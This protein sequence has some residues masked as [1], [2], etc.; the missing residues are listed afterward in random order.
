MTDHHQTPDLGADGRLLLEAVTAISSDLDLASVLT[1]I[2][3]AA[4]AL[5]GARYGA[6][7]VLGSTGDLVEFVTTGLDERTR[8]LIGDLPRGR[9]ILGVIIDDPSG[10]RLA[11]LSAHPSSVGFPPNHPPMTSFLGMPVRIRGTVFGNLYL[12]EKTGDGPFTEAD[13]QL[14]EELA[15]TAGYV[16]SNARSFALSERRRQWLEASAELSELLQPPVDLPSALDQIVST[17]RQ[18]SHARAVALWSSRGPEH[19]TVSVAPDAD[20]DRV[21][22]L[23]ARARVVAAPDAGGPVHT[24]TVDGVPVVVVPLRSHL[25]PVTALVAVAQPGAGLLDVQDRD[26]FAGFADQVALSLDRTQALADRQELALISDRERIARDLHDVVIQRLFATGLQLQGVAAMAGDGAVTERLDSSVAELDDTIKAIRGTIFELQDRRG[27]S[28]RASVRRLVKEYVPVLGFAPV[29]RTSGPVDTVVPPAIGTQLLA[30]LREAISNVARHALADSAQV[31]VSV[32]SEQLELRVADD[33]V[34][35]PE[36]VTESG[37]RNARRRAADLGGTL[38]IS[39]LGER[40]TVL[41]WHV[42]LG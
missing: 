8:A 29:V 6:L 16:I 21:E 9:G 22:E 7:G 41:V 35:L 37:L 20:T 23:L 17:A 36:D 31:D 4:T 5:T 27:D 3:E 14:V 13:E 34:G 1:R 42:P 33:G 28:L 30:V 2:V 38:E 18:V 25:A 40:G 24:S 12:T 26:L 39:R 32:T 15:R 19:D 11:D 10:L